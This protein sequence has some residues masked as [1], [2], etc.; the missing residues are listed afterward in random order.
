MSTD[1]RLSFALER[2]KPEDWATFE[3]FASQYLAPDYPQIR[4]VGSP[5][6]DGGRDAE[7]F[8]PDGDPS[9]VLQYSVTPD[10][11]AKIRKTAARI[12]ENCGSASILIYVSNQE[13]GALADDIKKEIRKKHGLVLDL[14]DRSWFVDRLSSGPRYE[15]AGKLIKEIAEPYLVSKE[16]IE[17]K[18]P[19]LSASEVKAAVVHL[20]L[21]WEDD[22]REKGLTKLSYEALVKSVLRDTTLDARITKECVRE[23]IQDLLAHIEKSRVSANVESAINRLVGSGLVRSHPNSE[24]CLAHEE[25]LRVREQLLQREL[26]QSRLSAEI[27]EAVADEVASDATLSPHIKVLSSRARRIIDRFL[28]LQGERFASQVV[29]GALTLIDQDFSA[30]AS[31]DFTEYPEKPNLG[32]AAIEAVRRASLEVLRSARPAVQAYLRGIADSYTLFAFMR[33]TPDVQDVVRKVFSAASIWLDTSVLLPVLAETLVPEEEQRMS[34]LLRTARI[35]GLRLRVTPGVV[36]E[37]ERHLN[38]CITYTRSANGSWRGQVPFIYAIY[39][40]AGRSPDAFRSWTEQFCGAE[41]PRDDVADYLRDEWDIQQ[42][43]LEEASEAVPAPLRDAVSRIWHAAHAERRGG[44][45]SSLDS[46]TIERLARHDSE[47]FLGVVQKRTSSSASELGYSHWWLTIDRGVWNIQ[48]QL[49]RELGA[50]APKSPVMSPDF[51]A[52]YLSVG[53]I[54]GRIPKAV[55]QSLPVSMFDLLP[56]HVPVEL[57]QLAQEVRAECVGVQERLIRRRLRDALDRTRARSGTLSQAGLQG[58]K[59]ELIRGIKA[60]AH[61]S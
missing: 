31:N 40:V 14:H 54:R 28:F 8:S 19:S 48:A 50:G 22:T 53:P 58:A 32:A 24:I 27:E 35:A 60:R 9:V 7:L 17:S 2:L 55:E 21:Q 49:Q 36:E 57:V 16:L 10:W 34:H 46:I 44:E 29:H 25:V 30:I 59:E 37:I 3:R 38:R 41:R 33:S 23:K 39:A 4:S 42:E 20:Q 26:L 15:V 51:L 1:K 45:E 5:S 52:G 18:A 12:R 43:S 47:N 6:G 11:K 13:I 61:N 56:S